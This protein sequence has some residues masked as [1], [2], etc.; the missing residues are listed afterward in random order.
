MLNEQDLQAKAQ[1]IQQ[2]I[3]A[4]LGKITEARTELE[5]M[6]GNHNALLGAQLFA[7]QLIEEYVR[8]KAK[9]IDVSHNDI[10]SSASY[11]VVDG[12]EVVP[13]SN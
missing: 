2:Q 4:S 11:T 12:V 5:R 1:S 7:K 6:T 9:D 3:D 8:D 13:S 10:N